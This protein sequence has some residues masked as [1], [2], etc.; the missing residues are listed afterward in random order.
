M[1]KNVATLFDGPLATSERDWGAM[2]VRDGHVWE[3]EGIS[4][5]RNGLTARFVIVFTSRRGPM[6]SDEILSWSKE[7]AI[8][9]V[10]R[11]TINTRKVGRLLDH[12]C[13]LW[14]LSSLF[15][16]AYTHGRT[17]DIFLMDK[18]S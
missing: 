17:L 6:F 1:R 8:A 14:T 4:K 16:S 10:K 18:T 12:F 11:Q 2:K 7:A 15:S 13:Y 3:R 9:L 5:L